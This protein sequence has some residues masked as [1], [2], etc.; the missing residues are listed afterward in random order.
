[1]SFIVSENI[2]E[3]D[4][5]PLFVIDYKAFSDAPALLALFPGGLDPS[6]RAQ[7]VAGFKAGLRFGEAGTVAAKVVD[8]KTAKL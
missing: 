3:K 5:D 6:V 7:N 1:M 4:F 8:E 2:E